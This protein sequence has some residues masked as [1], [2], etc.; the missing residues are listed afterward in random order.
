MIWNRA[1]HVQPDNNRIGYIVGETEDTEEPFK[2]MTILTQCCKVNHLKDGKN[3]RCKSQKVQ[4]NVA[5]VKTLKRNDKPIK[6]INGFGLSPEKLQSML[7]A[8]QAQA[9]GTIGRMV[10][11][12]RVTRAAEKKLSR[13]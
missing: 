5:D 4:L 1:R 10:A 12:K 9:L 8:V 11:K 2:G 3:V 13:K 6:D 7:S